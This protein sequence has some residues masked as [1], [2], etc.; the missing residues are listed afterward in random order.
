[1][2]LSGSSIVMSLGTMLLV[3]VCTWRFGVMGATGAAVFGSLALHTSRCLLAR[4]YGCPY[5]F[6]SAAAWGIGGILA[7]YLLVQL[8]NIPFA[9]RILS[10][11]ALVVVASVRLSRLVSYR[12]VVRALALSR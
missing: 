3:V 7:V 1:M 9:I 11:C 6:E 5:G 4:R 10:A 2:L 8:V 12:E